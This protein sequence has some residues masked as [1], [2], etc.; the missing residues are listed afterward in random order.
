MSKFLKHSI[1]FCPVPLDTLVTVC[2]ADGEELTARA[3]SLNWRQDVD[4]EG[5]IV[6]YR[7][8]TQ[9][10]RAEFMRGAALGA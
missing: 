7:E 5:R 1:P 10:E 9:T 6:E 8:A 4:I 2:S 3:G